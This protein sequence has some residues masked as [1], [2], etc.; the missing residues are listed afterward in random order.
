MAS[1]WAARDPA[2]VL[3]FVLSAFGAEL[4]AEDGTVRLRQYLNDVRSWTAT[5]EQSV[6]DP[7]GRLLE[8]AHGTVA[9]ERPARFRWDYQTPY[10]QSIIGD[11]D[12]VWIYDIDLAQVTRHPQREAIGAS[13]A[14]LLGTGVDLQ[15]RYT[16]SDLG[17]RDAI[18]WIELRPLDPEDQYQR[19]RL[20]FDARVL[21]AMVLVDRLEQQTV[22]QFD[23]VAHDVSIDPARF[24]FA[25][26]AGVDVIDSG[27]PP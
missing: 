8:T 11:G 12:S 25:P 1:P 14:A 19:I 21:A 13:P 6:L 20:G 5:F 18:S 27:G 10:E 3:S 23:A 17:T 16:V 24:R 4:R 26:P 22:L 2:W 7:R 9:V 15:T